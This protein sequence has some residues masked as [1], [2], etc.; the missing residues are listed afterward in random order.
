MFEKP[1][2][3]FSLAV[4]LLEGNTHGVSA[5]FQTRLHVLRS[6]KFC[7]RT[8]S[9][10]SR[11]YRHTVVWHVDPMGGQGTNVTQWEGGCCTSGWVSTCMLL[12]WRPWRSRDEPGLGRGVGLGPAVAPLLLAAQTRSSPLLSICSRICPFWWG[13]RY[14]QADSYKR[15]YAFH[16][17]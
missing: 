3:W 13:P 10:H 11:T 17:F 15:I 9:A 16:K 1:C 2:I 7:P 8:Q 12:E 14:G 4:T 5:S 6:Q